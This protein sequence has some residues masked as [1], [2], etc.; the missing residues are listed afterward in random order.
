MGNDCKNHI[1][2]AADELIIAVVVI[3]VCCVVVA[4]DYCGE[5]L[6]WF[7]GITSPK[8]Q[9]ILDVLCCGSG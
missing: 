5:K 3:V 6:A 4:A 9:Y 7:F 8:Y 2:I 1:F